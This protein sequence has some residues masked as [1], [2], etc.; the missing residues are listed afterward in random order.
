MAGEQAFPLTFEAA[1]EVVRQD[2]LADWIHFS[3]EALEPDCVRAR[4]R[5]DPQ[6]IA[7]TGFL[8]AAVVTAFADIACGLGTSLSLP[9]RNSTFATLEIKTNMLGTVHQ[10]EL[11]CEA[12]PRHLGSSTQVW[13][14]EAKE[15]SSGKTTLLFRCT[16]MILKKKK[17]SHP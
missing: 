11:L 7:P 5:V 10:G 17:E 6:H 9:D 13:D 16:Q 2:P 14:A 1:C 15:A 12:R 3:L 8:H 4:M